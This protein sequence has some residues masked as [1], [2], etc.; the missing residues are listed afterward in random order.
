[1]KAAYDKEVEAWKAAVDNWDAVWNLRQE[2]AWAQLETPTERAGHDL[3]RFMEHYFLTAG[4]PDPAKKPEPL[5]LYNFTD[6][7]VIADLHERAATVP[8]L[9]IVAAG[10]GPD[11]AIC[12]GWDR[13][14]VYSLAREIESL[15]RE[16]AR[17]RVEAAWEQAMLTHRQLTA[18]AAATAAANP[19]TVAP[20]PTAL[21]RACGSFALQCRAVTDAHE[22][23][24]EELVTGLAL[25]VADSPANNGETLRAAVELG[26][27]QGSAILSFS[28]P[29]LEWFVKRYDKAAFEASVRPYASKKR[30]WDLPPDEDRPA[31]QRR[32]EEPKPGR[33]FLRMR[34]RNGPD[35]QN[36]PDI[37]HGYLDFADDAWDKFKGVVDIPGVGEHV[38]VEGFRVKQLPAVEP[39]PWETYWP[40]DRDG[41]ETSGPS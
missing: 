1:M 15:A 34:G 33:V 35:G 11:R 30:K 19:Y 16:K 22:E 20:A 41:E 2:E 26:V 4:V 21:R 10:R 6:D 5:A 18:T 12:I 7:Q 31:K 14:A 23:L 13:A 9:E 29:V 27:F 8:H 17:K 39:A 25:D 37:Q 32:M 3:T 38:E 36:C 28:Q 24:D 40:V